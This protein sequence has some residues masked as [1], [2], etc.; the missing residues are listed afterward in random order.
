[1]PTPL[2]VVQLPTGGTVQDSEARRA[3]HDI[4]WALQAAGIIAPSGTFTDV[5]R[6]DSFALG[7]FYAATGGTAWTDNTG[8]APDAPGYTGNAAD[9]FGVT[10]VDGRVAEISLDSNNLQGEA[11]LGGL[12]SLTYLRCANNL[13]T[14]SDL[15]ANTSLTFLYYKNNQFTELDLLANT[16]LSS[17]YCNSNH[18]TAPEQENTVAG[19]YIDRSTRPA[20]TINISVQT[21]PDTGDPAPANAATVTMLT[22][23]SDVYGW[24][25]YW[26]E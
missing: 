24:T 19:M 2:P 15:L 14:E 6:G 23:L 3:I 17:A 16:S 8:W 5:L 26:T 21:N 13:L 22:E 25:C 12:T 1:V 4:T 11:S 10:V 18:L 9:A 7:E 20:T